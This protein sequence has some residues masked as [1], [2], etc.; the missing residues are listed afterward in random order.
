MT[1]EE[2][3]IIYLELQELSVE[4]KKDTEYL[5]DL[6]EYFESDVEIQIDKEYYIELFQKKYLNI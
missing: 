4:E 1:L 5:E 2:K 3:V 6:L